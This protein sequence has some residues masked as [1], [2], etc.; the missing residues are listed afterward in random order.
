MANDDKLIAKALG[1]IDLSPDDPEVDLSK[2]EVIAFMRGRTPDGRLEITSLEGFYVFNPLP[3]R[4]VFALL[5]SSVDNRIFWGPVKDILSNNR[6]RSEV[7]YQLGSNATVSFSSTAGNVVLSFSRD[8][9]VTKGTVGNGS[10]TVRPFG[11]LQWIDFLTTGNRVLST[12]TTSLE[13]K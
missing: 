10:F 8:F 2:E 3:S 9:D 4:Q 5:I 1:I 6:S 13:L 12:K 7:E 11:Y